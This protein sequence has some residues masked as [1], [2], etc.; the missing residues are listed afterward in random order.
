LNQQSIAKDLP[1]KFANSRCIAINKANDG[2][3]KHVLIHFNKLAID[4][5]I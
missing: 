4:A 1:G 5:A 3:E 2:N